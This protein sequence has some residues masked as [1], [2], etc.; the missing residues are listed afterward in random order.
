LDK[1]SRFG[2][3]EIGP[4]DDLSRLPR[5]RSGMMVLEHRTDRGAYR[6]NATGDAIAML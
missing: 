4:H 2:F 1:D 5:L 3:R 6:S